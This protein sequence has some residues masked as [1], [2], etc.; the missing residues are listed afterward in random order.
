MLR[1]TRN[2]QRFCISLGLALGLLLASVEPA[3]AQERPGEGQETGSSL[4]GLVFDSTTM[5]PLSGA[6]VVVMG[7]AVVGT[8]DEDG[9]FRLEGVPPGRHDVFFFHPRLQTLGVSAPPASV[10][11]AG[12][13]PAEVR[14]VIPSEGTLLGAWC[15]AESRGDGYAP[16]AGVVRDTL[17]GVVLPRATVTIRSATPRVG[18]SP[19]LLVEG[20]ADESGYYRFCNVPAEEPVVAQAH[21]GRNPGIGVRMDLRPGEPRVQDLQV[22][23]STVGQLRGRVVE[24]ATEEPVAG[25]LVHLVGTGLRQVTD[26]GGRFLLDSI[27][28]GRH[29]IRTEHLGFASRSDSV[30]VFSDEAVLVEVGLTTE[31]IAL[32]GMVVTARGRIGEPLGELGR[33]RD[34]LHRGQI[35]P[36]LSRVR[37]MQDLLEQGHFPALSV[38]EVQFVDSRSGG[39]VRGICIESARVQRSQ[40]TCRMIHVV[41]DGVP[42]PNPGEFLS[43]LPPENVESI[44]YLS[45]M[46]ATTRLGTQAGNG[47][48]VITTRRGRR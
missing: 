31:P 38:R 45:P 20:K 24:Y 23:I 22:A 44:E 1:R 29:E 9:R 12:D 7:T 16:V 37:D 4:V 43:L 10:Q 8:S 39:M 42:L 3:H 15:L 25:A 14:L 46:D 28:P 17:T 48:L 33:R 18:R 11:L 32:E 19:R 21:F 26:E 2:V 6:R 5:Q 47:A 41:V 27:P 35:E 13:V 34:Y 36:L 40:A 30:T